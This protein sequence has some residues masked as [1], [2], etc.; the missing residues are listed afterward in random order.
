MFLGSACLVDNWRTKHNLSHSQ[1][2]SI[3]DLICNYDIWNETSSN[4]YCW[5]GIEC[6]RL[7][8]HWNVSQLVSTEKPIIVNFK[9]FLSKKLT[10]VFYG[11]YGLCDYPITNK[12]LQ[13]QNHHGAPVLVVPGYP[14]RAIVNP[15]KY[16]I[17]QWRLQCA[18]KALSRQFTLPAVFLRN[19]N[20]TIFSR[21]I[22]KNVKKKYRG[23]PGGAFIGGG[24]AYIGG[25][26]GGLR[27]STWHWRPCL[28][29]LYGTW[30]FMIGWRRLDLQILMA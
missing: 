4:A 22:A 25:G 16:S 10:V 5:N 14:P 17:S 23:E 6:L 19:E 3:Y 12:S 20:Q 18:L 29:D 21:D 15:N 7:V 11:Y 28:S 26:G 2:E 1:T 27:E 8:I 13:L 24:G 30:G 9:S